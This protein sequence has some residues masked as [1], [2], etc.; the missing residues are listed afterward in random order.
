M[1]QEML[2]S[3]SFNIDAD[4]NLVKC[5]IEHRKGIVDVILPGKQGTLNIKID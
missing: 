2:L 5:Y 3:S 1:H 4:V